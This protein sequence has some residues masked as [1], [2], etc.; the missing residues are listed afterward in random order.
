MI[1][2][3]INGCGKRLDSSSNIIRGISE[4]FKSAKMFMLNA[5]S[6]YLVCVSYYKR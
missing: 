5:L 6:E 2:I 4:L 1:L 3:A